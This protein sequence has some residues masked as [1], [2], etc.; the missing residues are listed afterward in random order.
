[1]VPGTERE[2]ATPWGP[3][4]ASRFQSLA[5]LTITFWRHIL[6]AAFGG[7]TPFA[8]GG[9]KRA[10]VADDRET[11]DTQRW[12]AW[13]RQRSPWQ[14]AVRI[15]VAAGAGRLSFAI[16]PACPRKDTMDKKQNTV[17]LR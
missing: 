3:M 16:V 9:V 8:T 4:T 5:S 15:Y 11:M 10:K 2:C 17:P 13:E 6:K 14:V 7:S 12:L 1:M